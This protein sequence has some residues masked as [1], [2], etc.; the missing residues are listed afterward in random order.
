[1][2]LRDVLVDQPAK[3]VE[4]EVPDRHPD[5]YALNLAT[6]AACIR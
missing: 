3:P 6:A 4:P 5:L 1:V 2:R